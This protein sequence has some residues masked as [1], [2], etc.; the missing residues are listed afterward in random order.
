MVVWAGVLAL[1]V[2]A[3][4]GSRSVADL[5]NT[6]EAPEGT[7]SP[8]TR[9]QAL[10][11]L[12]RLGTPESTA[13]VVR[14]LERAET[15]EP[16]AAALGALPP[17]AAA[18]LLPRCLAFTQAKPRS[19][20][21]NAAGRLGDARCVKPLLTL[22]QQ[23][24]GESGEK[25][26]AVGSLFSVINR[27]KD[28]ALAQQALDLGRDPALRRQVRDNLNHWRDPA[29]APVMRPLL[30]HA[31][32][33]TRLDA[34][35]AL[36]RMGDP[37]NVDPL[38]KAL[39]AEKESQVQRC[40]VESLG[41][42]PPD[43]AVEVA[44]RVAPLWKDQQLSESTLQALLKLHASDVA[45]PMILPGLKAKDFRE[46][47]RAVRALGKL[48]FKGAAD[49]LAALI[50]ADPEDGVRLMAI[51]ALATAATTADHVA[52]L[53]TA[54]AEPRLQSSARDAMRN[55]RQP[56]VAPHLFPLLK[57]QDAQVRRHIVRALGELGD[58]RAAVPLL[59]VVAQDDTD[60]VVHEAAAEIYKV[61]TDDNLPRILKLL[62]QPQ[63]SIVSGPLERAVVTV[64]RAQGFKVI[65]PLI[66]RHDPLGRRLALRMVSDVHPSDELVF[67]TMVVDQDVAWRREAMYGLAYLRSTSARDA[68][69]RALSTE[70]DPGIRNSAT[71]GL[72]HFQDEVAVDCLLAVWKKTRKGSSPNLEE[73]IPKALREI[74]GQK[75]PDDLT[76]WQ[77]WRDGGLGAGKGE[78]AM[79]AALS[80]SNPRVRALAA[81][82]LMKKDVTRNVDTVAN[83]ALAALAEE[84]DRA[85][86]VALLE[87]LGKLGRV[88]DTDALV[89]LLDEKAS[90]EE[91]VA[92]ARALDGLGDGRGTLS[93]VEDLQSDRPQT[94]EE[95]VRALSEITGEPFRPNP[96][97]WQAWWKTYAERYRRAPAVKK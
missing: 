23:P 60:F 63:G 69:C 4:D 32:A 66:R 86:R 29:L 78:A 93:F 64:D 22:I 27:I 9:R 97:W 7:V 14:A 16:A 40:L 35:R 58:S 65:L 79:V 88:G 59:D 73:D 10:L 48:Q 55:F 24:G 54:L 53:V 92:L 80:H 41:D 17:S 52:V 21:V 30:H 12:A 85:T 33:E 76:T 19:Y 51:P 37:T 56:E 72:A 5:V 57:H 1:V 77:T 25:N 87:L 38:L 68:L 94:R 47:Q 61:A 90:V 26:R 34:C 13:A 46:R 20:C 44:A 31:D 83:A 49:E 75:F 39:A 71:D 95:A 50:T 42:A 8:S 89:R 6:V 3:Q 43:R 15:V 84:K 67:Q 11:D 91:R 74:S 28:P 70:K 96:A 2:C 18:E 81:R 82:Q 45:G 62:A 36:D